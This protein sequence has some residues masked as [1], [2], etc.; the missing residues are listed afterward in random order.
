MDLHDPVASLSHLLM[1]CW[2]VLASIVLLRLSVRHTRAQRLSLVFYSVTV[3]TL[4][5][6]SGLF[7][8]LQYEGLENEDGVR[9]TWQLLD[10]TAIFW[11]IF[12]SNVPLL[13]YVLPRTWRNIQLAIM[14]GIALFGTVCLWALPKPPHV[15]LVIV[16][17]GMGVLGLLP[18]RHYFDR[19]GWTGMKWIALF[20]SFY[21]TGGVIEAVKWP[22]LLTGR[23]RVGP[24]ELLHLFD[25]AGTLTHYALLLRVVCMTPPF[26][27]PIRRRLLG[28]VF[29]LTAGENRTTL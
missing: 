4:Y 26:A 5:T 19:L 15:L 17:L 7:H 9:R 1:A 22:E 12:G 28:S 6:A 27:A 29:L 10:Q 11:L 20:A 25:M 16:Y 18:I 3:V 2:A 8:G 23:Y 21:I 24:H 14:G 13:V